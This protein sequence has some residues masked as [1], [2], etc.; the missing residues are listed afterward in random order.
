MTRRLET[1]AKLV[2]ASHNPGKVWEIKQLIAPYGLDAISAADLDLDEP[3]E[4]EAT[5]IGNAELKARHAALASNLPALA[6]DSGLEVE[7][8]DGAPGIYSAR[9][10]GPSKDFSLAMKKVAGEITERNAWDPVPRANFTCALSLVWPEGD[11]RNFEGKVFGH[12]VWPARGGNGFG[13]DPMFVP[14]G[15]DQT[16]GEM[17]PAQKHAI[18]H[19]TRAFALFKAACLDGLPLIDKAP[20]QG[21]DLEAFAAAARNL[22]TRDELVS[23]VANLRKDQLAHGHDWGVQSLPEFLAALEK[24]L[25]ALDVS[26]EEPRWR[27]L[28]KALFDASR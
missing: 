13:Y 6:D 28:A 10:A 22:S 8:L 1:G 7:C 17:E 26:E 11:T 25:A 19:R 5:F 15:V 20:A 18:S 16:F 23:F 3:E 4:T 21:R 27:V 2:V 24:S 9:W 12:L 14:D